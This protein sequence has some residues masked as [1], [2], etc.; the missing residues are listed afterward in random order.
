MATNYWDYIR[1]E[2]LLA[3]Q[4]GIAEDENELSNDEVMFVVI[5][6]IHEL[7]F[8]LVLKELGAA[9]DLFHRR[10]VPETSLAAASRGLQRVAT[11]LRLA[12]DHLALMETMTTRDYLDFRDKLT[13]ASGF[14]SAQFR[15]VEILL[16][17]DP[18]QRIHLG[19]EN[20]FL[21]ALKTAEGKDSPASRRVERRLAD[22]PSLREAID[23]WLY[24]TPIDGSQ[25]NQ[26]SDE[27]T[28][29]DFLDQYLA[30]QE[31]DIDEAIKRAKIQALTDADIERL[32]D[33]YRQQLVSARQFLMHPDRRRRRIQAA[34]L[35]IES[36]RELPL[37]A[38]PREIVDRIVELEQA[39]LIHRQRHARMVER[40]IG[41]RVGTGGSSGVDYLDQTALA[42]RVFPHI[43]EVRT[44]LL[45]QPAL[46]PLNRE[47]AYRFR[48]ETDV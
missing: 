14:Q 6:Q 28:V 11:I 42:Y 38:W 9:R 17:L 39:M 12:T 23:E 8:K 5:H 46:P 4:N 37:L 1:V 27:K 3:L 20:S 19:E 15:E 16:G 21:D 2:D 48:A 32:S 10:V 13:P 22:R 7:W 33:R 44:L 41:R 47:G 25:P 29:D 43:W 34:I 40:M 18:K 30:S 36:Y 31:R 45:R 24:R 35:F 26:E